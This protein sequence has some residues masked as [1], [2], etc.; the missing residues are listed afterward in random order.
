MN[1]T[2]IYHDAIS[3]L[4]YSPAE[5]EAAQLRQANLESWKLWLSA[6]KTQEFLEILSTKKQDL[7][8]ASMGNPDNASKLLVE[9]RTIEKVINTTTNG[10]YE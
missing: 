1:A 3:A 10:V 2:K 7:L 8:T 4:T 5:Q 9:A 6:T